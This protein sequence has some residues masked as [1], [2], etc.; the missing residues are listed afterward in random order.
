MMDARKQQPPLA[1]TDRAVS[2]LDPRSGLA[3]CLLLVACVRGPGR[4]Q[5]N[6]PPDEARSQG[7][8]YEQQ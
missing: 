7:R 3:F 4:R 1:L 2:R 6:I 8:Q 5:Q